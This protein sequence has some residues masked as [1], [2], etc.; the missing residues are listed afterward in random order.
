MREHAQTVKE[1]EAVSSSSSL[2]DRDDELE[3]TA[4]DMPVHL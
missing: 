3:G 1:G 2:E 4:K